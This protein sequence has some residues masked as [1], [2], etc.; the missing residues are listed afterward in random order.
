MREVAPEGSGRHLQATRDPLLWA[1]R[2]RSS[3]NAKCSLG[4]CQQMEKQNVVCPTEDYESALKR[5]ELW[6]HLAGSVC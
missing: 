4:V 3:Q 2:V 6:G 1:R 5:E